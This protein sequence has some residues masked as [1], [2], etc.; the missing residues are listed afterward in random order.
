[1]STVTDLYAAV[2]LRGNARI[3]INLTNDDG[4]PA[5]SAINANRLTA[6]C[7]DAIGKFRAITGMDEDT[8]NYAH[9]ACLVT[10]VLG[11]L[12]NYKSREGAMMSQYSRQFYAECMSLKELRTMA[13]QTETPTI[14]ADMDPQRRVFAKD[15]GTKGFKPTYYSSF[16]EDE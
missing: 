4:P 9:V 3:L 7:E 8:T 2:L 1:M 6:A 10:G 11:F 13:G 12:E 5:P 15:Y 14:Q 16:C